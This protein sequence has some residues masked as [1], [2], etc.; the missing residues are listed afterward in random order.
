MRTWDVSTGYERRTVP[1]KVPNCASLPRRHQYSLM[2]PWTAN[3]KRENCTKLVR[4]GRSYARFEKLLV[5]Y[6]QDRTSRIR[7]STCPTGRSFVQDRLNQYITKHDERNGVEMI[8]RTMQGLPMVPSGLRTNFRISSQKHS[9]RRVANMDG[10][11]SWW[12]QGAKW[13]KW[14]SLFTLD[15][16]NR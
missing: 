6:R 14:R 11:N 13:L 16:R 8:P 15:G 1:Y 3:C 12:D 9:Q 4:K 5:L 10:M 2:K 7:H